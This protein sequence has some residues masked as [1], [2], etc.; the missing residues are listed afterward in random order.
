MS[1]NH[2]TSHE[3]ESHGSYGSYIVGFVLA[4]ILTVASFATVLSKAFAFWQT[5][6]ILAVLATVQVVVHL[7][8]FLH[9]GTKSLSQRQNLAAFIITVLMV[10]V[11][12]A[13]Y[14]F[15]L[16]DAQMNMMPG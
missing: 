16:W 5:I 10:A 9:M 7:V 4:V 12:I 1:E 13:G 8:F 15:V 6:A 2:T 3:G 11:V 14:L